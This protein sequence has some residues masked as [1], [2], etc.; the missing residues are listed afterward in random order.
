[1]NKRATQKGGAALRSRRDTRMYHLMLLIPVLILFVYNILPIPAGILMSF[2]N[3]QPGKGFLGSRFVGM[4]NFRRLAVLPDT[5]P[6]VVNTLH[7]AVWKIFGNLV[8][9][10]IFALLLNEIETKWFKR[11]VQTI[12]YLPYF[13]SWVILAGIM[14]KF[15]SPGSTASSMG[16]L[17]KLLMDIGL[18]RNRTI[19]WAPMRLSGQPS[20]SAISGRT[21]A[22]IPLCILRRSPAL[23][24]RC[25]KRR[26]STA[27]DAGSGCCM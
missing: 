5:F 4:Q 11:T 6:A 12:T 13:L 25:M 3:F 10:V 27:R 17:N 21:S 14:I 20:S 24:R 7:I 26:R 23:I 9:A 19:S 2:Q 22:T 15:L 1:M 16:F 8:V 18:S